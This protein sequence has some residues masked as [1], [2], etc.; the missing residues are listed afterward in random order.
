MKSAVHLCMCSRYDR[1]RE[2]VSRWTGGYAG[3]SA[4]RGIGTLS[5]R[6]HVYSIACF[7]GARW[8]PKSSSLAGGR[9]GTHAHAGSSLSR[10]PPETHPSCFLS[11]FPIFSGPLSARAATSSSA[12]EGRTVSTT[13]PS[14]STSRPASRTR[15]TGRR[16][17][18][19]APSSTSSSLKGE[20]HALEEAFR[21]RV[22]S[23]FRSTGISG[24]RS[25][26]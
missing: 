7:F 1:C 16:C 8:K 10:E 6:Q 18:P 9:P 13:R 3:W 4:K 2:W 11:P 14:G 23:I 20:L 12:W 5:R 25:A 24:R 21:K 22:R 26:A 17:S 19:R 15:T